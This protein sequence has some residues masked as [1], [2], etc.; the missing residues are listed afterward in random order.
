[1]LKKL[2]LVAAVAA[3]S[4]SAHAQTHA[5]SCTR[6][7]LKATVAKYFNAVETHTMSAL[8]MAANVRITENA[9]EIKPNEGFFKT[10][11]KVRLQRS[12]VDTGKCSTLTQAVVDESGKTSP[13][14]M[15]VRL[16]S[17]GGKVSEIETIIA[18]SGDF[19]FKPQGVLDSGDQDW[20]TLMPPAQRRTREFLNGQ[21]D[22]YY[23]M[24]EDHKVDPGF[25]TPCNRWENGTLTTAKGDCS[26]NGAMMTHPRRRFPVT[27]VE[28]G[29]AAAIT[30]FRDD[31]LDVHI[32]KFNQ[33]GKIALIQAV[34]GPGTKGT[35]WPYDK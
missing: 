33:D 7:N 10:G 13:V 25:A 2:A 27:D 24:F 4:V 18:R 35:G 29:V 34:D 8:P 26:W 22:K 23:Q 6:D 11:G 9:A 30:N 20:E 3:L 21:A 15:A 28:L 5:Q 17:D 12:I 14:L 32:F 31:W 16:R 1:M 19:A